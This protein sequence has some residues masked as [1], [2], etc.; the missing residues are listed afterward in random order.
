MTLYTIGF[1]RRTAQEFFEPIKYRMIQLLVDVRLNNTSQMC[2]F[3][4][5]Q[6]LPYLLETICGCKYEHCPDYAPTQELLTDWKKKRI[7]WQEYEATYRELMLER[8]AVREFITCCEGLYESVCLLCS[9][10]KPQHCHRKLFAEL[11]KAELDETE[12][13]HL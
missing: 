7:T 9:E 4:K 13:I 3:T 12:I 1:T 11:V 6:D 10:P 8:G 2:G 5:K